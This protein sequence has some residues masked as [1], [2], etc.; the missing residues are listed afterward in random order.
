PESALSSASSDVD[1]TFGSSREGLCRPRAIA[2]VRAFISRYGKI[3]TFMTFLV[4]TLLLILA[5]DL[6]EDLET[7]A[8]DKIQELEGGSARRLFADFPLLHCRY[9]RVEVGSEYRLA[10]LFPQAQTLDLVCRIL[11]QQFDAKRLEFP[12]GLRVDRPEIVE[13]ARHLAHF[14]TNHAFRHMEFPEALL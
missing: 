6:R 9:A 13:P 2:I 8:L 11:L 7:L 14:I 5:W 3:P 1:H 10:R 4:T 12:H